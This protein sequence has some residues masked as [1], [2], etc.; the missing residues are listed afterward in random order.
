[1]LFHRRAGY[2][3]HFEI[4]NSVV[5]LKEASSC[6]GGTH[7]EGVSISNQGGVGLQGETGVFN[8]VHLTSS[9]F[10][11]LNLLIIS[12]QC[13]SLY[14][15]MYKYSKYFCLPLTE[16]FRVSIHWRST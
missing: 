10:T 9:T 5:S 4:L 3:T 13:F 6:V 16:N 7:F 8:D 1:M 11:P 12:D 14:T 15:F 2:P